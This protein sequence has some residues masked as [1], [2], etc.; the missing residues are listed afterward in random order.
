MT[1]LIHIDRGGV[2][3][4]YPVSSM[5]CLTYIKTVKQAILRFNYDYT[6]YDI[7]EE[8]YKKLFEWLHNDKLHFTIRG[9]N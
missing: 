7:S 2:I 5:L 9:K 4:T 6:N 1:K 3:K 8:T